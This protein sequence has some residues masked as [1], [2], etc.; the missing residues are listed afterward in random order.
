M[1]LI[2]TYNRKKLLNECLSSLLEQSAPLKKIVIIDNNSLDGTN[3]LFES[4]KFSNFETVIYKRLAANI[5]GAGGF[6]EGLKFINE[7]FDCEW[8][9][10]MD[11]DT[12]PAK[13]ALAELL[14]GSNILKN[15]KVSYIASSIFGPQNEPMNVPTISLNKAPNGYSFWYQ[16]LKEGMISI[17]QATFVS[18]LISKRAIDAV[19]YPLKSY[20]IW[21]DDT[22]YTLRLVENYGPAFFN[23]KSIV[24]HKRKNC[25]ALSIRK[26]ENENRVKMYKYFYRNKLNNYSLYYP[27]SAFLWEYLKCL[28]LGFYLLFDF[29]TSFRI[30][31]SCAVQKAWWSFNWLKFTHKR[32]Q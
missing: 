14:N 27:K 20:F 22:E 15:E 25:K 3:E 29:K 21:G 19:G 10:I 1:A 16:Y 26:E 5:G 24:L 8:V 2:V 12:I 23:G 11:D 30:K 6:H 28:V 32:L 4:G 18:L 31:K 9:W 17:R 13:N 7:N